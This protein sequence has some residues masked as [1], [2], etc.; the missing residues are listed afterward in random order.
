MANTIR[1]KRRLSGPAGAPTSLENAELAFNEVDSI[2]YYGQGTGGVGGSATSI[3]AI[4]GPGAFV[5]LSSIQTISGQKTFSGTVDFTGST[6]AVTQAS[7][8]DSTKL[9][10]TAF[11][12]AQGYGLGSVT[13]VGLSLPNIFT[14]TNSP[15][16]SSGTL[17]ATLASQ[18]QNTV[19]AAPDGVNGAPTFRSLTATDIPSLSSSKISD[20]DT[21]VRTSRLDQMAAPTASVSLNNQ[22]ITNL[23]APEAST[24]AAT[25]GYV[26]TAIAGLNWKS[27]CHL[28]AASNVALTGVD[29]TLIIDGHPALTAAEDGYRLLLNGQST[30]SENGIYSYTVSSGTYTLVRTT[31]ADT[32]QELIG[33]AVL[34]LEGTTYANTAW[35]QSNHYLTSFSG[36]T[37]AQFNGS[38]SYD[39]GAGL[40]LTGNTFAVGTASVT[41]IVVNANDIDLATT[42]VSASTYQ[43]V[44]VDAYGRVTAGSNPTTLA[45]YGITDAQPLDATLTALA[46]VTVA[47]DQVIYSTAADTFTVTSLTSFGRNLIGAADATAARTTLGLGSMS[48]QNSNSVA[49]TGGTIDG[50][51]FDGGS[52]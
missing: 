38:Q 12:K 40:T 48:T 19:F 10:T 45:G 31:D 22:K 36:Q 23:A 20:F 6:T 17:T 30:A 18:T 35:V 44:T 46:A 52:F 33:A 14:V 34:V 5:T 4:A 7:S 27:S 26:D 25:R 32:Y 8:D 49:I 37:W 24:D 43:S 1:I 11:V 28:R 9:A 15:V 29:G 3:L 51:T 39:A 41:R 13:S 50:V 21:Q 2:L 42:G 16:T 47:A